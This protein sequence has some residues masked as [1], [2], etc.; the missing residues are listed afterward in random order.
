M[1]HA[2]ENYYQKRI[3]ELENALQRAEDDREYCRY[4]I[5]LNN[6]GYDH[7]SRI[8]AETVLD[9]LDGDDG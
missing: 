2:T 4:V 8:T 7:G 9:I 1:I 6:R 3:A 5:N